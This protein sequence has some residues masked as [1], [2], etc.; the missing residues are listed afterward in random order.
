[1]STLKSAAMTAICVSGLVTTSFAAQIAYDG[2]E[3]YAADSRLIGQN[4]GTGWTN[5]WQTN[6]ISSSTID[7]SARTLSGGGQNGGSKALKLQNVQGGT[8]EAP[9]ANA[10]RTL[11]RNFTQQSGTTYFSFLIRAEN[12]S[13]NEFIN[14]YIGHSLYGD[15]SQ[16]ANGDFNDLFGAGLRNV[17]G[18]PFLVRS[19]SSSL[20]SAPGSTS[21]H[22]TTINASPAPVDTTAAFQVVVK[23]SKSTNQFFDTANL[24][25]FDANTAAPAAESTPVGTAVRTNNLNILNQIALRTFSLGGAG[26]E[27]ET[28]LL[29]EIRIGTTW[30]SVVVIPEPVSFAL[31]APAAAFLIRRR[32]APDA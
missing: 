11:Y 12:F 5:A 14:L 24:W 13:G 3:D 21:N 6:S 16:S 27:T 29:D 31:L 10:G 32:R 23:I 26:F 9:T 2:F 22:Y 4:Q 7:V 30:D 19:G 1:M 18:N 25:I 8:D 17:T 15:L 20:A 28:L